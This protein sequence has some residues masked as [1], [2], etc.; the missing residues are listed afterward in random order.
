LSCE[1]YQVA[2]R[3]VGLRRALYTKTFAR[4]TNFERLKTTWPSTVSTLLGKYS[5]T[6]SVLKTLLVFKR[7]NR[8]GSQRFWGRFE[9]GNDGKPLY[10]KNECDKHCS[11]GRLRKLLGKIEKRVEQST[12]L[13]LVSEGNF[14]LLP[15][16]EKVFTNDVHK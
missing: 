6:S 15:L 12:R 16:H 13:F 4:N 11:R 10:L 3:G 8:R 7:E 5:Q 14:L 2:R 1:S 9:F